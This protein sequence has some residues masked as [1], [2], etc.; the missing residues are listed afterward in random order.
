M[1]EHRNYRIFKIWP[2]E[3]PHKTTFWIVNIAIPHTFYTDQIPTFG[4]SNV[5][6]SQ[7]YVGTLYPGGRGH[8][9]PCCFCRPF[10]S[11]PYIRRNDAPASALCSEC[12][13][14]LKR[15]NLNIWWCNPASGPH[16]GFTVCLYTTLWPQKIN[17][18]S[19]PR[20]QPITVNGINIA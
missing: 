15:N 2:R 19:D 14:K 10:R 12:T 7:L 1:I 18:I 13:P 11:S 3:S 6:L 20:W 9:A 17:Q 8:K 5:K 16:V 4:K